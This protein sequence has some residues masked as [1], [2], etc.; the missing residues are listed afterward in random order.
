MHYNHHAIER[1]ERAANGQGTSDRQTVEALA[2][3][4]LDVARAVEGL[5]TS[6]AALQDRVTALEKRA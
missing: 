6:Y 1:L 2:K 4:L 5:E 3:V